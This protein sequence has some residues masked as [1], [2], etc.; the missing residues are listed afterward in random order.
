[1]IHQIGNNVHYENQ[2]IYQPCVEVVRVIGQLESCS[3]VQ[4]VVHI[5]HE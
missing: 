3:L 5:H 4:I 1:M 2:I